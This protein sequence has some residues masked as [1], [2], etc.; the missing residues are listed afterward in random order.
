MIEYHDCG[1][2]FWVEYCPDRPADEPVMCR[3]VVAWGKPVY[4]FDSPHN[5][6]LITLGARAVVPER[7]IAQRVGGYGTAMPSLP[8]GGQNRRPVVQ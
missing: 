2:Q 3:E 4:T 1:A 7:L 8:P 5:A 6:T